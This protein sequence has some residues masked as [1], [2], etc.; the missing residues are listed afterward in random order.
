MTTANVISKNTFK[1]KIGVSLKELIELV[2]TPDNKGK[3][4]SSRGRGRGRSTSSKKSNKINIKNPIMRFMF[5]KVHFLVSKLNK[6]SATYT[7]TT[8]YDYNN[9]SII[10]LDSNDNYTIILTGGFS[11]LLSPYLSIQHILDM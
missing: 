2:Y 5:G 6:I 10:L 11:K 1:T 3:S 9:I 8:S 4:S 7:Y